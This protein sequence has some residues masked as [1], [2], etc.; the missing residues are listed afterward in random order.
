MISKIAATNT[1]STAFK[2]QYSGTMHLITLQHSENLIVNT[3][4]SRLSSCAN[5]LSSPYEGR[6]LSS[7]P[8]HAFCLASLSTLS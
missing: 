1:V 7:F 2:E 5:Q 8:F 4:K 3:F 6:I